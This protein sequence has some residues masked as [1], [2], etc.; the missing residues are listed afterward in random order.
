MCVNVVKRVGG[1]QAP[2]ERVVHHSRWQSVETSE[3]C[4]RAPSTLRREQHNTL[5]ESLNLLR[6]SVLKVDPG[7][8][9]Y[10]CVDYIVL[11]QEPV[12]HLLFCHRRCELEALQEL[13]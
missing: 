10:I 12:R 7:Y 2:V 13:L 3:V 4:Q 11:W 8:L 5:N 6:V 9:H 1:L